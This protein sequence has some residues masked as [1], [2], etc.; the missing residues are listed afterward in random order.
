MADM[1]R[2][3]EEATRKF[4]KSE[5]LRELRNSQQ[6]RDVPRGPLDRTDPY[7]P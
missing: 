1:Q 2:Q 6:K 5:A 3:L 4:E 7:L